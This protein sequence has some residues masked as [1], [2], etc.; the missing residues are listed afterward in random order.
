MQLNFDYLDNCMDFGIHE[1][2]STL[3]MRQCEKQCSHC[4]GV[5]INAHFELQSTFLQES[6]TDRMANWNFWVQIW[7]SSRL[8]DGGFKSR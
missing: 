6:Q 7:S 3:V 4:K 5:H 2:A 1:T 8:T